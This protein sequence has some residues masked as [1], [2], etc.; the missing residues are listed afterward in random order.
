MDKV[1]PNNTNNQS[2]YIKGGQFIYSIEENLEKSNW[3]VVSA[4]IDSI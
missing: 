4:E 1:L 3:L 2:D